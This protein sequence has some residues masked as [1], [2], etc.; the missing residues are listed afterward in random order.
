[1]SVSVSDVTKLKGLLTQRIT[2]RTEALRYAIELAVLDDSLD[3]LPVV[4]LHYFNLLDSDIDAFADLYQSYVNAL[5]TDIR[6]T[7]ADDEARFE[8]LAASNDIMLKDLTTKRAYLATLRNDFSTFSDQLVLWKD[9]RT[10]Q[11]DDVDLKDV[12]A[13]QLTSTL[14]AYFSQQHKQLTTLYPDL[15]YLISDLGV[16]EDELRETLDNELNVFFDSYL[17]YYDF[18]DGDSLLADREEFMQAYYLDDG[19]MNCPVI[20]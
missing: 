13:N 6:T 10:R 9:F 1:M 19:S 14:N 8:E 18:D 4:Q 16:F 5:G 2:D 20:A 11:V 3:D 15:P 7:L 12:V 17:G